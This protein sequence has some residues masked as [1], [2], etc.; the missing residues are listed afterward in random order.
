MEQKKANKFLSLFKRKNNKYII[1]S[2]TKE[3]FNEENAFEV[4]NFNF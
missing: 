2:D 4:V 1:T 3:D